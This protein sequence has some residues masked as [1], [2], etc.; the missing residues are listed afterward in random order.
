MLTTLWRTTS[1]TRTF[2]ISSASCARSSCSLG[3]SPPGWAPSAPPVGPSGGTAPCALPLSGSGPARGGIG[4]LRLLDRVA[5][6]H[7]ERGPL[8]EGPVGA[9]GSVLL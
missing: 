3:C 1:S 4:A 9:L 5:V 6:D 7:L 8:G 2:R